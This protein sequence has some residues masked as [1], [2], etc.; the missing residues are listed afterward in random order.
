M[1][2]STIVSAASLAAVSSA[3]IPLEVVGNR[4]VRPNTDANKDGEEFTIV[5]IDYQP[6]GASSYDESSGKDV[7]SDEE[8]CL[9][10]AFVLQQLGVNTIRVYTVNPWVNHDQ[11][12][13]IFNAVG[14]YVVLDVA[15]PFNALSRTDPA[16]TYNEGLLNRVFGV[17]DAFKGYPNTL[18]FFSGNEVVNDEKSAK[19][20]P[21]YV[22]ALQRDMKEYIKLHANRTI[23]VGYSAAD[24]DTLRRAMWAYL[25]CD[26]SDNDDK[27]ASS[28]SDFYGLNS[29]DWCSG[30]DD[31]QSSGYGKLLDDFDNSSI[32]V[33]MSEYGCNVNS[34]RT[35]TE[36]SGGVYGDLAKVFSGGLI[37][38]YSQEDSDYGLV[39]ID[40]DGNVKL[41][42]DY[43]NL[44]N[45]YNN[46]TL[47]TDSESTIKSDAP[48][49]PKC[50]KSV[51]SDIDS[52]FQTNFTLPDCPAADMLK[53]GGGNKNIGKIVS[54]DKKSS[55][56]TIKNTQGDEIS[57]TNIK[58]DSNN[59]INQPTGGSLNSASA[60]AAASS[61]SSSSSTH[62]STSKGPANV[63]AMNV[64]SV[65]A[66]LFGLLYML[67]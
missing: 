2:L 24:D 40:D 18:G 65:A 6:G 3:L 1:K 12:M 43:T 60:T 9:R 21:Q 53:N 39:D 31:W 19:V 5:G 33:F 29:Y 20:C 37:Y 34:P 14:I 26:N 55:K 59:E 44:Q 47:P 25:E 8:T 15:S 46:I 27:D 23:P 58:V 51:V 42:T 4:F 54:V 10:D 67:I 49:A 32:P 16:S 50:G 11:C 61:G 66:S 35:F 45:Q 36:V 30:R 48:K 22:R 62:S 38:E 57:D 17:I 64:G 28:N 13:S 7:L 41:R 63:N 52:S 56:Y